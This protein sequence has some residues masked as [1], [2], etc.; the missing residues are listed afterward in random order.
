MKTLDLNKKTL[1]PEGWLFFSLLVVAERNQFALKLPALTLKLSQL[2]KAA[3]RRLVLAGIVLITFSS[4]QFREFLFY[5]SSHQNTGT[6][7][8]GPSATST[9]PPI[10]NKSRGYLKNIALSLYI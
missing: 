8:S 7:I 5:R 6:R 2:I 3:C 10:L 1:Y 9:I 4:D